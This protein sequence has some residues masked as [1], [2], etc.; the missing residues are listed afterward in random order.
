[1]YPNG[2]E[3]N[4]QTDTEAVVGMERLRLKL[5]EWVGRAFFRGER[6]VVTDYGKEVGAFIG[7]DE[8]NRLRALEHADALCKGDAAAVAA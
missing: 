5:T 1:M 2:S 8:L 3:R 6:I 7:R 4:P